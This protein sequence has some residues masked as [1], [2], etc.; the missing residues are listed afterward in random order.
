[1]AALIIGDNPDLILQLYRICLQ[2]CRLYIVQRTYRQLK[3]S[4]CAVRKESRCHKVAVSPPCF[5]GENTKIFFVFR[6]SIG[7]AELEC[8]IMQGRGKNPHERWS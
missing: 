3:R 7:S 4:T 6:L 8:C 2:Y 1:M 5:K